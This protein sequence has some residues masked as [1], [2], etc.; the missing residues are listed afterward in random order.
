MAEFGNLAAG[1]RCEH[2]VR[3]SGRQGHRRHVGSY[4]GERLLSTERVHRIARCPVDRIP[5]QLVVGAVGSSGERQAFVGS[6]GQLD[7]CGVG[8]HGEPDRFAGKRA[9]QVGGVETRA[10]DR[11]EERSELAC[12]QVARHEFAI[13]VGNQPDVEPCRLERVD[14][15]GTGCP[16]RP[17]CVL[18]AR[19]TAEVAEFQPHVVERPIADVLDT[20]PYEVRL[21]T[22]NLLLGTHS[23]VD[24]VDAPHLQGVFRLGSQQDRRPDRVEYARVCGSEVVAAGRVTP[25]DPARDT[26]LAGGDVGEFDGEVLR[27][28]RRCQAHTGRQ[29]D[30]CC[31][32]GEGEALLGE[33]GH[34]H[35]DLEELLQPRCFDRDDEEREDRFA[36]DFVDFDVDRDVWIGVV[37]GGERLFAHPVD[38]DVD[39]LAGVVQQD[40]ESAGKWV[41]GVDAEA[42]SDVELEDVAVRRVVD[43]DAGRDD[44]V[45][46]EPPLFECGLTDRP[47]LQ[48]DGCGAEATGYACPADRR[49][50]PELV[51]VDRVAPVGQV[52]ERRDPVVCGAGGV[53]YS[54]GVENGNVRGADRCA[55]GVDDGDGEAAGGA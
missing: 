19:T 55:A 29:V 34:D 10:L 12:T 21:A 39:D 45:E 35:G 23:H 31:T 5:G 52:S 41:G 1:E 30:C 27:V 22:A 13:E 44:L 6:R 14:L 46:G 32:V 15:V 43:V 42:E 4:L 53:A 9:G 20:E 36:F 38:R 24:C 48:G 28:A 25:H 16:V 50:V 54:V 51:A 26:S 2:V 3:R 11:S 33:V 17:R 49:Q 37:A 40:R 8:C 7:R 18:E 47:G